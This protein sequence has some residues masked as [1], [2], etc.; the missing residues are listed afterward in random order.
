MTDEQPDPELQ[1]G[2]WESL[3][4]NYMGATSVAR[5]PEGFEIENSSLVNPDR[6]KEFLDKLATITDRA[7]VGV[8]DAEDENGDVHPMLVA[9][10]K[11]FEQLGALCAPC[12]PRE[13]DEEDP[14]L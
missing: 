13:D 1:P 8:V 12:I 6:M 9:Q 4:T 7:H 10:A 11:D 5:L 3:K 14:D 2:E